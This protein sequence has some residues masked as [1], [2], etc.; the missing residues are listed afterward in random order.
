MSRSF[1]SITLA[2]LLGM[3]TEKEL[4]TVFQEGRV[5][6][7]GELASRGKFKVIL[8]PYKCFI[9]RLGR[10]VGHSKVFNPNP[11]TDGWN[12]FGN[13]RN[14]E[15]IKQLPFKWVFAILQYITKCGFFKLLEGECTDL[16]AGPVK[17]L[18][19]HYDIGRNWGPFC[20]FRAIT[21]KIVKVGEELY[22]GRV[23]LRGRFI[24]WFII[25]GE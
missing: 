13:Y 7:P 4:I 1:T 2:Q 20:I 12:S 6:V 8:L 14:G 22:L 21:D 24:A 19:I 23:Y 25:S 11:E 16:S 18:L 3:T 15:W 5:P 10:L 17:V 9:G